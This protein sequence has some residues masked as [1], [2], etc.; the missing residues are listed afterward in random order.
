MFH[1]KQ[2]YSSNYDVIVIGGGH[3][4]IEAANICGTRNLR[5]LMITTSLEMIGQMSCNPAI[6]GI[7]KGNIVREIDALGGLMGLIADKAGIHFRMLNQSKGPAVWGNRAQADKAIYR[8]LAR[9]CLENNEHVDLL[10]G[11]VTELLIG[12]DGVEGVVVDSEDRIQ[13]SSVIVTAGTFL[14]GTI[15]IGMKS[16]SGGRTGEPAAIGLTESIAKAGIKVG[17]LKTGTSPRID[18]RSVDRE[19]M[20][21]QAGDSDPWPFSFRGEN[22]P[23]NKCVCLI[24][25]TSFE[26]H[27]IIRG[28]LDRSPL[29]GGKIKSIG[30]R[31]CPSIE[32][33]VVRFGDREGHTLFLEPEGLST[34]ELY[35]NG[36]STSLP[37]DVQK[38]MV[39][40]VKG[41]EKARILRPG[42]AIEYD[43]FFP[44]QLKPTLESK[45][46]DRL[47]FAGQ[48]NGTSGY[49]EAA[50]Q[51][52][53]AGIN[54]AEK[55]QQ[56]DP[57]I[58][59][60]E[61]SYTGVLIDDLVTKGTQEPYRM[62]TSRAEYRLL[63]RQDNAD[64]RLMPL[65][66]E[67]KL[68]S[69]N[70][71]EKRRKIWE[72]C[73]NLKAAL[74]SS[75]VQVA[76]QNDSQ[77][78]KRV[79][80]E[81]YLRRPEV[82]IESLLEKLGDKR[83]REVQTIVEADVKYEGFI[84]KQKLEIERMKKSEAIKIPKDFNYS[85]VPGLLTESRNKL[86]SIQPLTVGQ[87]GRVPGVT[88]A[89]IS[90]LLLHLE[91]KELKNNEFVSRET[92]GL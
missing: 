9:G 21:Q 24:T 49:E 5:T 52:L 32:D 47:F 83:D 23:E 70:V 8:N 34:H 12:D 60:R 50:C 55:I 3:A 71:M 11:C 92:V 56:G 67:R 85:T 87:A 40:S 64:Q 39:E 7:A 59:G 15:H 29:Y 48:V 42:Y 22:K 1:V 4:G 53:V 69:P 2:S 76:G 77:E 17:R 68:I 62:F 10:Q 33:K 37:V 90:V 78:S 44:E 66:V 61:T 20:E 35:L 31:Y 30:P 27:E 74:K 75:S 43:F 80:G 54:A 36:L 73:D 46:V 63:L 72:Q 84:K 81:E 18:G 65:A 57:F 19:V 51:G 58:L 41:L 14:N 25:K 82:R 45:V 88:P 13:C 86:Q 26:T 28:N 91:K 38:K 79:N 6:G 16:I 89:D